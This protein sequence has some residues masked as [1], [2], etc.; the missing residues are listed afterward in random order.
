MPASVMCGR[1]WRPCFL[2]RGTPLIQQGDEMFRTQQ[3]NNNAYAQDNEITWVDWEGADGALVDFVAA[4]TAFRHEHVAI[5]HDR[6]CRGRTATVSR[7]WRGCIRMA[8]R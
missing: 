4:L 8:A 1:C 5:T 6:S 2:S 3:G 7:M